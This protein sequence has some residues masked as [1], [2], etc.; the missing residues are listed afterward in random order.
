MAHTWL[1]ILELERLYYGKD[2]QK[3]FSGVARR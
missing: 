1:M 2:N 3:V